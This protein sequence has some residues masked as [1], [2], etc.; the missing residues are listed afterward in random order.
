MI[1]ITLFCLFAMC[2]YGYSSPHCRL[3]SNGLMEFCKG[4]VNKACAW[5]DNE[6]ASAISKYVYFS[7]AGYKLSV[8][9]EIPAGYEVNLATCALRF[10]NMSDYMDSQTKTGCKTKMLQIKPYRDL[11]IDLGISDSDW[12]QRYDWLLSYFNSL[13]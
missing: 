10:S 2:D 5:T 3:N 7:T 8:T 4:E 1:I 13:P 11:D 9:T 6:K 12:V